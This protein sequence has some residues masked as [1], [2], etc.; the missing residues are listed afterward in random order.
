M[1][2]RNLVVKE[3]GKTPRKRKKHLKIY[4][5]DAMLIPYS[6]VVGELV[7]NVRHVKRHGLHRINLI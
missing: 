2:K 7:A 3:R 4:Q 1:K 6:T 5:K